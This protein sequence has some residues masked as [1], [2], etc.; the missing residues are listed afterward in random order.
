ML[1]AYA[2]L[3]YFSFLKQFGS[4]VSLSVF[5]AE[6]ST[7]LM[8]VLHDS[9]QI[10]DSKLPKFGTREKPTHTCSEH[11]T[12]SDDSVCPLELTPTQKKI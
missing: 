8:I 4:W 7:L 3:K 1:G 5:H 9:E 11:L 6:R 2:L 10:N 12:Y